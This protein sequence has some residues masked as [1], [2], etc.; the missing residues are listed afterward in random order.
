MKIMKS[1]GLCCLLGATFS[2][3]V[4]KADDHM[5]DGINLQAPFNIQ[6]NMCKLNPGV[7][8]KE[9]DSMMDEYVEWAVSEEVDPVAVRQ[10][11][12]FTH[13]NIRRPWGYDFVDFLVSDYER[14]GKSWDLWLGTKEGMA[15]NAKWQSLAVCHVKQAH[16]MML[17]A[18][19]KAMAS[20][21]D[22]YVSW[23][24]CTRKEG[25]TFEEVSAKHAEYAQDMQQDSGGI[26]GWLVLLPHT[27]GADAAGDFAHVVVYPDMASFM[28][29]RAMLANGGWKNSRDYF[30][31]YADCNGEMLNTETVLHRP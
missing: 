2:A 21:D 10:M 20:D 23:N 9:Y 26:I 28:E 27:G 17:Y 18:D 11:P 8:M 7:S 13:G 6:A 14:W 22:R 29:R 15:L 4:A 16:A 1:A 19:Q 31:L 3:L 24:W 25:V 12:L 5:L 30:N